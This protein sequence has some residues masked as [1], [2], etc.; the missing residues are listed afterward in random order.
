MLTLIR[1]EI[2]DN[3]I[4]F[5]LAGLIAV[6]LAPAM[7]YM[8]TDKAT[9][10]ESPY[11]F[12]HSAFA[13]SVFTLPGLL[14]LLAAVTGAAQM[15]MDRHRRISTFLCTQPTTRARILTARIVTGALVI[16]L[17]LVPVALAITIT[18]RIFYIPPICYIYI[19][20]LTKVFLMTF[21]LAAACYCLGLLMGWDASLFLP[22]L[23]TLVLLP[24]LLFVVVIKGLHAHSALIL[25]ALILALA[26]RIWLNFRSTSL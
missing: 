15:Y 13:A 5:L 10:A 18:V 22:V 9:H 26:T 16:G 12:S 20:F 7:V 2:E 23:G 4:L 11:R 1:R 8:A 6:I 21:L 24:V 17:G 19:A 25:S 14:S 3:L